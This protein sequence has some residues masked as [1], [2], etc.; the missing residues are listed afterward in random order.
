MTILYFIL[1]AAALGILVFV[2]ELGHFFAAR[3]MGMTVE[4]FSIGF[5]RPLLKWKRKGVNWQLGWLPFG[6][7][8]KILGMEVSKKDKSQPIVEPYDIPN[9]FFA[10]APWRR[11]VVALAGPISNFIV[12]FLIFCIL[13]FMGGREK[14]FSE[15]TKIVG[16]VDPQSELYHHG[17]RPG[18]EI[19]TVNNKPFTGWKDLLYAAML[20]DKKVA[21]TGNHIDYENHQKTP[22]TYSIDS[23]QM[24]NGMEGILTT[25]VQSGARY[26]IYDKYPDGT[27]NVLPSGS[28]ML[29][30]GIEYGD[31]IVWADGSHIFSMENLS[32]I[33]ND[34]K[35]IL[36]VKRNNN[37]FLTR[38]PRVFASD[39][40]VPTHVK[41]ELIDWAYEANIKGKWQNLKILPYIL[42]ASGVV[43]NNLNFIDP[44]MKE[45]SFSSTLFSNKLEE[46]LQPG[47]Q[48]TS[49]GGIRIHTAYQLL[50]LLQSRHVLLIV[51]RGTS[52]QPRTSAANADDLFLDSL[53]LKDI[54][55]IAHTIGTPNPMISKGQY[56]LLRPIEPKR[57]EDFAA[58]PEA[59]Q[60]ILDE[61]SKQRNKINEI[62]NEKQRA[63][64]YKAFE[65]NQNKALLGIYLQDERVIY[66]PGPIEMF[67]NVFKETWATLKALI[68]GHL[69]PKWLSGPV[70][71]VQVI[72]HGWAIG[73]TEALFWIGAISLNLGFLNLLP[74]PVLDGGYIVLSLWEMIT[75]R[76]VKAKTIERLIIPFV[77]LLVGLLIFL[78]FQ[79]ITRLF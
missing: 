43:E 28:P 16:W 25:G 3:M 6:G 70:G 62:K 67:G 65:Q 74:I 27:E 4:A 5:G 11:M 9:G 53:N 1:A 38:Q 52:P 76:K 36:T 39:L 35:V 32:H 42:N 77:I 17:L 73:V 13:F 72:H 34:D 30:S 71:I 75:K 18:D 20:G 29:T 64:A 60:K 14:P 61:I 63:K 15:F 58:T 48:I 51:K 19:E 47:D 41:N 31:R 78:T 69:S 10:K 2:H 57:V 26:L 12:A 40:S 23:Y 37:Y 33:L 68:S 54:D 45:F 49:I 22:F 8:V 55:A 56:A 44:E 7:Y 59:R 79:D 50:D 46:P 66:N 21:I 24:P